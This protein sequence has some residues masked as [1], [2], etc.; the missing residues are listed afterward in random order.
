MAFWY[1]AY[2]SEGEPYKRVKSK[3][4]LDKEKIKYSNTY[5][6]LTDEHILKMKF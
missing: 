5:S 6:L 1:I 3:Y 4:I 2:F